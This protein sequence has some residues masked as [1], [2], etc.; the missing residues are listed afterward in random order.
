[1]PIK[2]FVPTAKDS[3][4]ETV[5]FRLK[6]DLGNDKEG[7][8]VRCDHAN[9]LDVESLLA[10]VRRSKAGSTFLLTMHGEATKGNA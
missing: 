1:M 3:F 5:N 2:E 6:N 4:Q 9:E 7:I 8:A 10:R